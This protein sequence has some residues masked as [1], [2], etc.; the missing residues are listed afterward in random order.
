MKTIIRIRWDR[1]WPGPNGEDRFPAR[2]T[3]DWQ[4]RRWQLFTSYTLPSLF[5][6]ESPDWEA[7][8]LAD[9][10]NQRF[11]PAVADNRIRFVYD[12]DSAARALAAP[13]FLMRIDSDDMLSPDALGRLLDPTLRQKYAQL[14]TGVA[15]CEAT[16]TFHRW[17][18]PSPPFYGRRVEAAELSMGLPGL[19]HHGH[20]RAESDFIEWVEPLFCVVLH[21]ANISN[22]TERAWFDPEALTG[23]ARDVCRRRFGL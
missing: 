20:A 2:L 21:G 9:A 6:L 10:T 7:W 13:I 4:A 16:Q 15:W 17:I 23:A 14:G 18:N 11:H 8:L 5:R 3:A 19:G 12:E 1:I 22:S